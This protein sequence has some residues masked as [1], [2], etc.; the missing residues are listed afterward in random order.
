VKTGNAMKAI[1]TF[2]FT[3]P[4]KQAIEEI[5]ALYGGDIKPWSD[6]KMAVK[7]QWEVITRTQKIH[8][9]LPPNCITQWYECWSGG[10]LLRQCDGETCYIPGPEGM[11]PADCICTM[12]QKMEC[13]VQTRMNM[14]LPEIRFG[15]MWRLDTKGTNAEKELPAMEMAIRQLQNSGLLDAELRLEERTKVSGGKKKNFVVPVLGLADSPLALISGG[16]VVRGAIN[17]SSVSTVEPLALPAPDL[18]LEDDEDDKP[19]HGQDNEVQDATTPELSVEVL[20]ERNTRLGLDVAGMERALLA[21]ST[22]KGVT[23]SVLLALLL[24]GDVQIVSVNASGILRLRSG[25][26]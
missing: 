25:R 22:A 9:F 11:E 13:K 6:P 14:V 2:R 7:N 15:G 23:P 26:R 8:I 24:D 16:G 12:K 21:T 20:V 4:D 17:T 10:G 18:A 19:D 5:A 1:D 3:S